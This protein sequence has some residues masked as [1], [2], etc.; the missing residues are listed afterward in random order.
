MQAGLIVADNHGVT[1]LV[2]GAALL[3][4]AAGLTLVIGFVT[5][6]G[7]LLVALGGAGVLIT[8]SPI[9]T[10]VVFDSRMA[11]LQLLVMSG[12][13]AILGPGSISLDAR[14]FGRRE[15]AISEIS[16]SESS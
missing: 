1:R 6:V 14:L 16:R 3:V 9:E 7:S 10:L 8:H 11:Q 12:A 4:M 5:P 13:L 15:I 2:I